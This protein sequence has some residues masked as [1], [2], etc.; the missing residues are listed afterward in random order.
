[1]FN[2]AESTVPLLC[3]CVCVCVEEGDA[4]G[5][6]YVEGVNINKGEEGT[7]GEGRRQS[8]KERGGGNWN[9]PSGIFFFS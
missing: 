5:R 8:R 2:Y 1:M 3:V 7:E 9:S 6:G 4:G